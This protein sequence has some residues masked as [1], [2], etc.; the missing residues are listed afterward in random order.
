MDRGV[1]DNVFA[2]AYGFSS[3]WLLLD[4]TQTHTHTHT[5]IRMLQYF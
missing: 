2:T 3:I 4:D 1:E 5:Q